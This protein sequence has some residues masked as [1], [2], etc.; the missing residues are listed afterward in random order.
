VRLI[1]RV[2]QKEGLTLNKDLILD[3]AEA[4]NGSGREALVILDTISNLDEGE[5]EQSIK[6]I[7]QEPEVLDLCRTLM[8]RESWKKVSKLLKDIKTDPETV[9]WSVLG[10]ARTCLLGGEGQA[11]IIIEMFQDNFFDSKEAGL[12]LACWNVLSN[13]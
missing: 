12:T 8:K 4:A 1:Q 3:I 5:R 6:V 9:R 10:Y 7:D 2:S 13:S 11:A